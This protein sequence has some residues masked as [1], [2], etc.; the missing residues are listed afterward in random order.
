MADEK[1]VVIKKREHDD[2]AV[3]DN[4]MWC[5]IYYSHSDDT[6]DRPLT[7]ISFGTI[8]SSCDMRQSQLSAS[9]RLEAICCFI[10]TNY[11]PEIHGTDGTKCLQMLLRLEGLTFKN[12]QKRVL[13]AH[14][15]DVQHQLFY[16]FQKN[17]FFVKKKR[18]C[19]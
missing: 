3:V 12:F 9:H 17:A 4:Q 6:E 15:L 13:F 19:I 5:I 10:P 18:K 2:P 16:Y 14:H 8:E 11:D 1:P 7:E